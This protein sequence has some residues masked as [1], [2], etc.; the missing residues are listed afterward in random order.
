MI[1]GLGNPGPRYDETRHNVG[2]RVIDVLA[3]RH[4][5]SVDKLKSGAQS[6]KG[7][8]GSHDVVLV[9]PQTF[10]NLSGEAVQPL[11]AFYKVEVADLLVVYDDFALPLGKLRLRARGSGGGHNGLEN[12]ILLLGTDA[13]P[14]LRLGVGP[15]PPH[16]AW[17][18]F[19]LSR[20]AP[21]DR[22]TVD[23]MIG[24]AAEACES[25]LDDGIDRAMTRY[26][27]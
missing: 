11:R 9:K 13:M 19:V 18:D 23:E 24:R 20:F 15:V 17:P 4:R 14:R 7:R 2:F 21:D 5:I 1:V 6:G 3:G 8:I 26:N 22:K 16:M 12:I 25:F 27:G 10:M